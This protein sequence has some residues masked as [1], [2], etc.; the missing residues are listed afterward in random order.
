MLAHDHSVTAVS[1]RVTD[2]LKIVLLVF[3]LGEFGCLLHTKTRSHGFLTGASGTNLFPPRVAATPTN[4][5]AKE[6][7]TSG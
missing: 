7:L 6:R 4:L 2:R 5:A 1:V 3:I